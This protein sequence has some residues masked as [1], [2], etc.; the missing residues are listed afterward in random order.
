MKTVLWSVLLLVTVVVVISLPYFVGHGL[1]NI[2]GGQGA[3][4]SRVILAGFGVFAVGAVLAWLAIRLVPE[5]T[6]PESHGH[7][8]H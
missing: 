1:A 5:A 3:Y 7:G 2:V 8:H 6:P 4:G